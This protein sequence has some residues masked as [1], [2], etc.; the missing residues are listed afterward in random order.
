MPK[1]KLVHI[2]EEPELPTIREFFT[3]MAVRQ[4]EEIHRLKEEM[5]LLAGTGTTE[6]RSSARKA[7]KRPVP[8]PWLL[9]PVRVKKT[10]KKKAARKVTKKAAAKKPAKK[11]PAAKKSPKRGR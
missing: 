5:G 3:E 7:H 2:G 6:R 10:R 1:S 11:K 8:D 4:G 9:H